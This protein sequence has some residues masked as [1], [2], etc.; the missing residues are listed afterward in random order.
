MVGTEL[1]TPKITLK[2]TDN[3]PKLRRLVS[4]LKESYVTVGVHE[5]AGEY[6]DGTLVAEV[7]LWNEFGTETIPARSFIRST[8]NENATQINAWRREVLAKV[9]KGEITVRRA[10]ETIGYRLRELVKNKINS[11]V[12]PPNA[13]STV[14]KKKRE[15]VAP[16]TLIETELLL[17]SIEYRVVMG[18]GKAA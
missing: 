7:A 18:G 5:G 9:L 2:V 13:P 12:P 8:L 1:I 10:L 16:R 15:G 4:Q 3:T 11:N 6:E 14:A 17:R